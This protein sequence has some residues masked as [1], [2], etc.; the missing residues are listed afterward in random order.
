M[1]NEFFV[2][3]IL[4]L[5]S[6]NRGSISR[7]LPKMLSKILEGAGIKIERHLVADQESFDA[8]IAIWDS[9]TVDDEDF[10]KKVAAYA[11]DNKLISIQ[12]GNVRSKTWQQL[13]TKVQT[14]QHFDL[15][16]WKGNQKSIALH[17]VLEEIQQIIEYP[18]ILAFIQ[19]EAGSI[20]NKW[21]YAR[22]YPNHPMAEEWAE[23]FRLHAENQ[24]VSQIEQYET[25]VAQHQSNIDD[26]TKSAIKQC[27]VA[28]EAWQEMPFQECHATAPAFV[29]PA[30][31]ASEAGP[32]LTFQAVEAAANLSRELRST[33]RQL[34]RRK[35]WL[36]PVLV[37]MF[38]IVVLGASVWICQFT[39]KSKSKEI[40]RRILSDAD[41]ETYIV[42]AQA[43][44]DLEVKLDEIDVDVDGRNK[45]NYDL[46][47][48]YLTGC[49]E[50]GDAV[51]VP[52]DRVEFAFPGNMNVE[53]R[54]YRG[55]TRSSFVS[56]V[57]R[58]YMELANGALFFRPKSPNLK[59]TSDA[60]KPDVK[61][62]WWG[63]REYRENDD[64][65]YA[66]IYRQVNGNKKCSG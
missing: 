23:Q 26:V 15:Q 41:K 60:A 59:N 3:R 50:R 31:D 6:N 14:L 20:D 13:T 39:W 37:C 17:R 47:A 1:P 34:A 51:D 28:F 64:Y 63:S 66:G 8:V 4:I 58:N 7:N 35:Y 5:A 11:K 57:G 40:E 25:L 52:C 48:E 32:A 33:E 24:I 9:K 45:E 27:R 62:I 44:R 21:Q 30:L 2:K 49:W 43:Q 65:G 61:E 53:R 38:A 12:G 22:S 55:E 56:T 54:C 29:A 10:V 16:R 36:S 42:L 18:P 19:A 46:F